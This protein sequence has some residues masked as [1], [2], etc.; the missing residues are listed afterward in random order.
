M[1]LPASAFGALDFQENTAALPPYLYL[2]VSP[3]L[4]YSTFVPPISLVTQRMTL[5]VRTWLTSDVRVLNRPVG[6]IFALF[7]RTPASI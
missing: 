6:T 7:Q 3:L 2:Q 5:P 4:F 1:T